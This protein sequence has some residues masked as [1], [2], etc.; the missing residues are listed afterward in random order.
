M[1]IIVLM[2]YFCASHYKDNG[3]LTSQ[4]VSWLTKSSGWGYVL[5]L[6]GKESCTH[7]VCK[8]DKEKGRVDICVSFKRFGRG[9]NIQRLLPLLVY[10]T[11][12][13]VL[14]TSLD[15]SVNDRNL[16]LYSGILQS[17]VYIYISHC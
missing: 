2:V 12:Q 15:Q 9:K 1:P 7:A 4:G 10:S 3:N 5:L 8:S 6:K 17:D 13:K 14:K 16:K 11:S